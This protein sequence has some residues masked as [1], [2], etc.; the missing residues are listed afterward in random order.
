MV[1]LVLIFYC[2]IYASLPPFRFRMIGWNIRCHDWSRW[3]IARSTRI[4]RTMRVL[5][6]KEVEATERIDTKLWSIRV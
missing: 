5:L 4:G 6:R 2:H 1:L 3:P